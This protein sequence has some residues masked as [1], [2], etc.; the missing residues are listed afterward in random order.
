M[1]RSSLPEGDEAAAL[2]SISQLYDTVGNCWHALSRLRE[3]VADRPGGESLSP[4]YA[5][6][7]SRAL[8]LLALLRRE[9]VIET[10]VARDEQMSFEP[11]RHFISQFRKRPRTGHHRIAY[12]NE[13]LVLRWDRHLRVDQR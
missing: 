13:R 5:M 12:A 1:H 9:N 6:I 4:G 3:R 2:L 10:R 8:Q 7:N 11:Q